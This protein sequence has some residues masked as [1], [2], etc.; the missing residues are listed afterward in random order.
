MSYRWYFIKIK[1]FT[2]IFIQNA[3][4]LDCE[5]IIGAAPFTQ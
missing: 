4:N 5:F 2:L 3:F 1:F